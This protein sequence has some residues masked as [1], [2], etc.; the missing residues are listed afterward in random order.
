MHGPFSSMQVLE[1]FLPGP[2]TTMRSTRWRFIAS[3]SMSMEAAL[4]SHD[5]DF[6]PH[7]RGPG[8]LVLGRN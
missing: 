8:W 5:V 3:C 4:T 2:H 1:I 6:V 7:N